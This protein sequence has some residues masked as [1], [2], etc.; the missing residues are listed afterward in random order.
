MYIELRNLELGNPVNQHDIRGITKIAYKYNDPF[1]NWRS[2]GYINNVFRF[3]QFQKQFG[4]IDQR[5]RANRRKKF[6]LNQKLTGG[7]SG[8]SYGGG[9]PSGGGSGG[10]GGSMGGGSSGGY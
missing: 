9:G 5:K 6:L 3:F 4:L 10:G 8:M 7:G 2:L 1:D